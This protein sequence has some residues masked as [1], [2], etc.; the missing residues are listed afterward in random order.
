MLFDWDPHKAIKNRKKHGIS[1]EM[2]STVFGD[3]LHLSIPDPESREEERWITVGRSADENTLVVVHTDRIRTEDGEV[4]RIISA[5]R[6]T[7]R[8]KEEYE[9]GI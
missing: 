2:A 7:R 5:R 3:P 8:E 4:L 1:F 6:A 9:E